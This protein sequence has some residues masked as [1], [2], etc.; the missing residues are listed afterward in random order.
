MRLTGMVQWLIRAAIKV[1]PQIKSFHCF[2]ETG[3]QRKCWWQLKELLIQGCEAPVCLIR[4]ASYLQTIYGSVL[5]S[6]CPR[7]ELWSGTR[8]P[9]TGCAAGASRHT[10][11]DFV[12]HALPRCLEL[13]FDSLMCRHLLGLFTGSAVPLPDLPLP[14]SVDT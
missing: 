10:G 13:W 7:S 8:L 9:K 12:F 14:T 2:F 11:L 6:W 1:S 4:Y 3:I 5:G